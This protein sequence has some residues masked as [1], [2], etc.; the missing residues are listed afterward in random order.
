MFV[1]GSATDH[2]TWSIQLVSALRSRF[3]LVA[4]DRRGTDTVA[5]QTA[6][7]AEIIGD[8]PA[9]VVGSSFGAVVALD[10]ARRGG[11]PLRGLVLIEP[12]LPATEAAGLASDS[13]DVSTPAAFLGELDRR[14]A[15]EGGPAAAEFF[16]RAVLGE[17]AFARIPRAFRE[18]STAKWREIR[19]DCVA[20]LA[21]APRYSEL[22]TLQLPVLLMGGERSAPYFARTLDVLQASLPN[23]ARVLVP[24][25]GHML[26]AEASQRFAALLTAFAERLEARA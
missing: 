10:L 24:G 26:H 18:R 19:A 14:I 2:A 16:L 15:V 4:Y 6:D 7:L 20:L 8:Q 21:Y 23:V 1:H 17:A 12:P 11:V 5:E 22:A 13:D 3:E 25:A 9:L